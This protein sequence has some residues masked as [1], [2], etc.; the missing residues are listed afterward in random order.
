MA[1]QANTNNGENS[2]SLGK[3]FKGVKSELKKVIWP[4]KK[5]LTSNTIIVIVS[6]ILTATAIWA[7]DSIFGSGLNLII[8]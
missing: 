5:E 4:N 7:L 8:G 2:K 1:T 6:V 3:F